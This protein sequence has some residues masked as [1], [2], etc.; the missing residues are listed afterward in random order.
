MFAIMPA[1]LES[2]I[3][4]ATHFPQIAGVA[5][6]AEQNGTTFGIAMPAPMEAG[7]LIV[8][9][10]GIDGQATGL[11]IS[12]PGWTQAT[13]VRAASSLSVAH[14]IVSGAE[15][16]TFTNG[17]TER[18]C[19]ITYRIKGAQGIQLDGTNGD[20]S[21]AQFVQVAPLTGVADYL[22]LA[23]VSAD[24]NK[25]LTA[26]PTDFTNLLTESGGS[27]GAS[28]STARR[29]LRGIVQGATSAPMSGAD[30]YCSY[31]IAVIPT[32]LG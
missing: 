14:K 25:V 29:F 24:S 28:V 7:D 4:V 30:D 18:G 10:F 1:H 3:G 8:C 22:Y 21:T 27:Q 15:T 26:P 13:N 5:N 12:E 19:A 20:S 2:E 32:T 6:T 9:V 17:S 31:T 16:L 23:A 11:A